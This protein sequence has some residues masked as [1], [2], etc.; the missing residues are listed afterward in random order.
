MKLI[1]HLVLFIVFLSVSGLTFAAEQAA[2]SKAKTGTAVVK[3]TGPVNINT[4]NVTQL[5]SLKLIGTKKAEAIIAYRKAH[6]NFKSV[7]DLKKVKG[8]SERILKMNHD[9]IVMT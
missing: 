1:R 3:P 5:T 2:S 7:E 6:G 8:I 9:R 4:A